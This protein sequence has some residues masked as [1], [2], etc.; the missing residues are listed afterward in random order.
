MID[1]ETVVRGA[2]HHILPDDRVVKSKE[3]GL[4]QE[5]RNA[6]DPR[7]VDLTYRHLAHCGE[8]FDCAVGVFGSRI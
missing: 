8:Y 7:Y 3:E 5:G 1:R 2:I 4:S 6:D